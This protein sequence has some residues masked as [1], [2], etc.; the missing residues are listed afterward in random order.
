M[1]FLLLIPLFALTARADDESLMTIHRIEAETADRIQAR[2][3]DPILGAGQSSIFVRM[4]LEVKRTHE[5]SDRVGIGR[6][7]KIASETKV[8][9]SSGTTVWDMDSDSLFMGFLSN[10]VKPPFEATAGQKQLQEAHQTRGTKEERVTLASERIGL[11]LVILHD[12]KI[13]P[14]RIAAVRAALLAVYRSEHADI[15]FHPVEFSALK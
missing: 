9:A 5:L 11:R 3:L 8:S 10:F 1:R 2:V 15:K 12:A 7:G 6:S 14:G 13:A 4:K